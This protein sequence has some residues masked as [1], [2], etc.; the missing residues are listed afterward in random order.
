[1]ALL[2]EISPSLKYTLPALMIGHI[3]LSSVCDQ[4]TSLQVALGTMLSHQRNVIDHFQSFKVTSSYNELRRFRI[5]AAAAVAKDDK[6][7]SQSDSNNGLVQVVADNFDTQISSQNGQKST[8][9]LAMIVTQAGQKG[10]ATDGQADLGTIKRLKWQK[11]KS[12]KLSLVDVSVKRFQGRKQGNMPE[13]CAKR[14]VA[15]LASLARTQLATQRAVTE[16]FAF[17]KQM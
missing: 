14:S 17:L 2:S 11:T 13:E 6:G 1:M 15:T 4:A 10:K 12:S 16:D 5:S 3:V 9:G 8:H 7:I